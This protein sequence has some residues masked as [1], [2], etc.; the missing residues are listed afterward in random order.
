MGPL[1][2]A[3]GFSSFDCGISKFGSSSSSSISNGT[4]D[5]PLLLVTIGRNAGNFIPP[6][7]ATL[8]EHNGRDGDDWKWR[9]AGL[10]REGV[11]G[12]TSLVGLLSLMPGVA[13]VKLRFD[14]RLRGGVGGLMKRGDGGAELFFSLLAAAAG[15]AGA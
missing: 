12:I 2:Y 10:L 15:A 8:G 7:G 1:G 4:S 13:I 5:N 14:G 9:R 11:E 6:A 3:A